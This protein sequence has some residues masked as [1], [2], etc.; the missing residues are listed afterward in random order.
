MNLFG[1]EV[2]DDSK[3][4]KGLRKIFDKVYTN[5]PSNERTLSNITKEFSKAYFNNINLKFNEES[6]KK[7]LSDIGYAFIDNNGFAYRFVSAKKK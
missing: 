7:F 2:I 3:G 5:I 6:V 1:Y 4:D